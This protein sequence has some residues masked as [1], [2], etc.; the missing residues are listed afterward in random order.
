MGQFAGRKGPDEGSLPVCAE[1]LQQILLPAQVVTAFPRVVLVRRLAVEHQV[2]VVEQE[3]GGEKAGSK[4]DR[5]RAATAEEDEESEKIA[6]KRKW[7][8]CCLSPEKH[9]ELQ[10]G[11]IKRDEMNEGKDELEKDCPAERFLEV[12]AQEMAVEECTVDDG[13]PHVEKEQAKVSAMSGKKP[14]NYY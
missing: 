6:T 2:E 8:R 14:S 11:E 5:P 12:L 13:Q 3:D 9:V 1:D 4:V 7:S 10:P